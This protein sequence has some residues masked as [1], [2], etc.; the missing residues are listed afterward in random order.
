MNRTRLLPFYSPSTSNNQWSSALPRT[1][2]HMASACVH[3]FLTLYWHSLCF[4]SCVPFHREIPVPSTAWG[5]CGV[6]NFQDNF[7][8]FLLFTDDLVSC[9]LPPLSLLFF[10][11][12]DRA[13]EDSERLKNLYIRAV[14][15]P[16]SEIL[17]SFTVDDMT[18]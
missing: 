12:L 15:I 6:M 14:W 11:R 10:S 2:G 4:N 3:T 16:Y 17:F 18:P 1:S 8:L 5:N 13:W 9:Y 7:Y